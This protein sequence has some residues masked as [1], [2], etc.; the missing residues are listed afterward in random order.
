LQSG[1]FFVALCNRFL[2][3]Y[4]FKFYQLL[5]KRIVC[6]SKLSH[7]FFLLLFLPFLLNQILLFN[8]NRI[9]K[10][11][12]KNF[13]FASGLFSCYFR[14]P[15][16]YIMSPIKATVQIIVLQLFIKIFL[17]IPFLNMINIIQ[18][19]VKYS[20]ICPYYFHKKN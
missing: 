13:Q 15:T 17:F 3:K 1:F 12:Y 4:R 7:C 18:Q 8:L 20:S 11:F 6:N 19:P 14:F 10:T 9:T 16:Q 2:F 5:S